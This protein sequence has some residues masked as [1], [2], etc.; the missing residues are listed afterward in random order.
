LVARKVPLAEVFLIAPWSPFLTMCLFQVVWPINPSIHRSEGGDASKVSR[1]PRAPQKEAGFP[2]TLGS[3]GLSFSPMSLNP[4]T[5]ACHRSRGGSPSCIN[6]PAC[7]A[8]GGPL[9]QG[10]EASLAPKV[11]GCCS[12]PHRPNPQKGRLFPVQG[13]PE[14][15]PGAFPTPPS[16]WFVRQFFDIWPAK[17]ALHCECALGPCANGHRPQ[18]GARG[19]PQVEAHWPFIFLLRQIPVPLLGVPLFHFKVEGGRRLLYGTSLG[20]PFHC[21]DLAVGKGR[22]RHAPCS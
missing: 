21:S 18:P 19:H 8:T 9:Q 20:F 3:L 11:G 6:P 10:W 17:W 16:P 14:G 13:R 15:G 1:I 4:S 5:P 22:D 2:K 7:W 12:R